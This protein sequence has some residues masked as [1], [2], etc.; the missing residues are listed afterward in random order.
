M[1]IVCDVVFRP[2]RIVVE[3]E[4]EVT[5]GRCHLMVGGVCGQHYGSEKEQDY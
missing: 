3:S 4:N 5:I 2:T 1:T